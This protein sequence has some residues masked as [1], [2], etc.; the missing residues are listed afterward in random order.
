MPKK[1]SKTSK[2]KKARKA[3]A[4]HK[5]KASSA[6]KANTPSSKAASKKKGKGQVKKHSP[7][8]LHKGDKKIFGKPPFPIKGPKPQNL[9]RSAA[10]SKEEA[11]RNRALSPKFLEQ[12][13]KKLLDLRDH[14]LDQMQGVA[15]DNL[16]SRPEG[17]EASAFGM[18]QADA[19][20]DAY[21]K[22][23]ALSL[24]SQEQD[25][26]YEIEQSLKRID[27]GLYGI[28]EMSGKPIP[29]NRMEAIPFARYTVEC[30]AQMEK[31]Q[32]GKNRWDTAPQFMDSAEGFF[33]EEE[34]EEDEEK[35]KVKD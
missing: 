15:Q 18:H 25:A 12:Q 11:K 26:L 17:N 20:S 6:K 23:F 24:L 21:E 9:E 33:E 31:E 5:P 28:C 14:I 29:M 7:S 35:Q 27:S 22:D 1:A 10:I 2:T 34:T 32:K 8:P 30:Q 3:S 4:V 19:G 13:K 16:R